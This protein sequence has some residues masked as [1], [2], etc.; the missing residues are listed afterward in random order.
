MRVV[1][2]PFTIVAEPASREVHL[3]MAGLRVTLTESEAADL[4]R[5]LRH[6]TAKLGGFDAYT[7]PPGEGAEA[8]AAD[9]AD[10]PDRDAALLDRI[11]AI[12]R[13]AALNMNGSRETL[14]RV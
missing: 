10:H 3:L 9:R 11:E 2:E 13:R 7:S 1:A 8:G 14:P 5:E 4:A 6:A 12:R